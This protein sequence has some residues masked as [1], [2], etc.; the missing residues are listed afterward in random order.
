MAKTPFRKLYID[1]IDAIN[2]QLWYH[3]FTA[4]ELNKSFANFSDEAKDL[5][6]TDLYAGNRFSRRIHIFVKDLPR[7]QRYNI[8]LSFGAF[9]TATYELSKGYI[10][11][12]FGILKSFNAL[13]AYNWNNMTEAERNLH[14]LL[15]RSGL[16]IPNQI[17]FD[18]LKYLRLRRNHFTHIAPGISP[19]FQNFIAAQ[20]TALNLFWR[21]LHVINHLDFTALN[22]QLFNQELSVELI[23]VIRICI[24]GIDEH[25]AG[26]L[27]QNSIVESV[28]RREYAAGRVRMNT[29]IATQRA[30]RINRI[31]DLEYGLNIGIPIILPFVQTIGV[32]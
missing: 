25:I 6:T 24:N 18:T 28:V 26:L 4:E 27:N 17:Y 30:N 3:L 5:Y 13:H 32:R 21:N 22:I 2:D 8:N 12:V 11:D 10:K 29:Y 14:L 23:K 7:F 19:N 15:T 9:Y 31:I 1:K 16:P 20:G